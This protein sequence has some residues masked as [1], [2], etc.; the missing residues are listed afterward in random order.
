MTNHAPRTQRF[1]KLLTRVVPCFTLESRV[2]YLS[3]SQSATTTDEPTITSVKG[4]IDGIRQQVEAIQRM[5]EAAAQSA[6]VTSDEFRRIAETQRATEAALSALSEKV[7]TIAHALQQLT[8]QQ[9]K[10]ISKGRIVTPF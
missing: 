6:A 3:M 2:D 4:E 10:V 9:A 8:A 1:R 5:A 7:D